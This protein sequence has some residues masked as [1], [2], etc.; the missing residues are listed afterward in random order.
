MSVL[1]RSFQGKD[2]WGPGLPKAVICPCKRENGLSHPG[3]ERSLLL[4]VF[5]MTP[6][7]GSGL[8]WPPEGMFWS[9]DSLEGDLQGSPGD[10]EQE[11]S[12]GG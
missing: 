6:V 10:R 8:R 5:L 9:P 3:V 11:E 12:R 4:P 1:Q 2:L 7:P